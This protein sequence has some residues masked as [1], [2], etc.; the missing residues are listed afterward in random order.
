MVWITVGIVVSIM[1]TISQKE[2]MFGFV[3]NVGKGFLAGLACY[4]FFGGIIGMAI[5]SS[6]YVES[7]N[8]IYGIEDK[9]NTSGSFFLGCGGFGE[10]LKYYYIE[11]TDK[12]LKTT[13]G[14]G[15]DFY[16]K[17][18]EDDSEPRI[19]NYEYAF[20]NR[21]WNLVAHIGFNDYYGYSVLFVPKDTIKV[22]YNIDLK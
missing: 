13:S 9:F 16:L 22:D 14:G 3:V 2:N 7:S 19:E 15:E 12:G 17:I 8:P 6:A 1:Y 11:E 18:I 4:I 10:Q 20:K 5:P 21:S